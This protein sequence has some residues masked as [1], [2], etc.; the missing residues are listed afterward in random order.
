[1]VKLYVLLHIY[2]CITHYVL[3][4]FHRGLLIAAFT[5][6]L[7]SSHDCSFLSYFVF[8][9]SFSHHCVLNIPYS[10]IICTFQFHCVQNCSVFLFLLRASCLLAYK[11]ILFFPLCPIPK[12]K[13]GINSICMLSL[14]TTDTT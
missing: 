8:S 12:F 13:S 11:P 4:G 5:A 6:P 2:L 1:M 7:L 3:Y 9:S 10:L 14:I